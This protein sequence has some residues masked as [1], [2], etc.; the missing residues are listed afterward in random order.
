MYAR[1]RP[2]CSLFRLASA[3]TSCGSRASSTG[4]SAPDGVKMFDKILIANRGE[5]ACRVIR[6][7]RRLGVRTVAVYSEADKNSMHVAMADEAYCIGPAPSSESYLRQDK[8]MAIAK[9]VGAQAIHPGYGFLSENKNFALL[10]AAEGVEFIGPPASAIEK[11]GIKRLSKQIMSKSSVP[12]VPGYFGDEQ[13]DSKLKDEAEKMGY[14]VMLKAD[15]GGG[16][17]GMRVVHT[18]AEFDAALDACR[19]E[20]LKSFGD[21]SVMVEKFVERPRHVEVQVFGDKYGDAVSLFERDC[22]VQRRHQKVIEE[23]PA[24]GIK[25]EVKE[26][27]WTAAV[28]AA[29]AVGYVGAGTVEFIMGTDQNFYFMEMNTRL[30]V[31]HPITEMITGLDLVEWQLKIAAGERIPI[32]QADLTC[33]GHSFEARIYAEDPDKGFIPSPGLLRHLA[34]PAPSDTIR[35][36]TGVRQGDEVTPFYDPLIAKLVVWAEDRPTA[37]KKLR[38]CLLSYQ[39]AGVSTNINFLERLASNESFKSADVHT[40]FIPQHHKELFPP[41]RT[42]TSFQKMQAAVALLAL[43]AWKPCDSDN[44]PFSPFG[45]NDGARVNIV[46]KR[47]VKLLVD[48]KSFGVLVSYKGDHSYTLTTEH[49]KEEVDAWGK[50]TEENGRLHLRGF[51]GNQNVSAS[52]VLLDNALHLFTVDGEYKVEVPRPMCNIVDGNK[53]VGGARSPAYTTTVNK[54]LVKKGDV[55]RK[56]AVLIA[57]EGMKMETSIHASKDCKVKEVFFKVKDTVPPNTKLIEFEE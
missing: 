36:D 52:V 27:L 3:R 11:M 32:K 56:G 20:A 4:G 44:D 54:V 48:N 25:Q 8:I 23:A 1:W 46:H 49:S 10:C 14:P 35:I 42:L 57:V 26:K 50:L 41:P 15:L 18:S 2:C 28:R 33:K 22:S 37:L 17:K 53:N 30:Q 55:V 47:T 29:Q 16:G 7:A 38:N 24:P 43:E 5:I 51:V 12:V 21:E 45:G 19:R 9:A 34:T 40:G 31:E 13:S 6:T 39:I